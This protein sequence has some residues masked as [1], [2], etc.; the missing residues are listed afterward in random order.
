VCVYE[1][2]AGC[3]ELRNS[4]LPAY[5]QSLEGHCRALQLALWASWLADTLCDCCNHNYFALL[6]AGVPRRLLTGSVTVE[7][8]SIIQCSMLLQ[9]PCPMLANIHFDDASRP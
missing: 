2:W 8:V 6:T 1:F 7:V 4:K 3:I 9:G 5:W